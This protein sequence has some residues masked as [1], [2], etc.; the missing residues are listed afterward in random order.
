M[1]VSGEGL[2]QG[3]GIED[4]GPG[5]R[6]GASRRELC[7]K[8][9][10]LSV[11]PLRVWKE[12][13]PVHLEATA[14]GDRWDRLRMQVMRAGFPVGETGRWTGFEPSGPENQD[15]ALGWV[16]FEGLQSWPGLE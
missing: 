9:R 10:G 5:G 6:R 7:A 2:W 4:S 3:A 12:G 8:A 15:L 11:S 16:R 13:R 1:R 14:E